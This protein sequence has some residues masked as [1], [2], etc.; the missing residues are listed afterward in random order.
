M[1]LED[2]R[3]PLGRRGRGHAA[4]AR[5]VVIGGAATRGQARAVVDD[6]RGHRCSASGQCHPRR[7]VDQGDLE[8]LRAFVLGVVVDANNDLLFSLARR[9]G[10]RARRGLEVGTGLGRDV[11]GAIAHGDGL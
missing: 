7:W 3:L 4:H 2:Q 6:G 1:H 5:T 10:Q 11:F 9:K 8:V